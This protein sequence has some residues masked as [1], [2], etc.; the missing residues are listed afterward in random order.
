MMNISMNMALTMARPRPPQSP[1][2]SS[3]LLT[4]ITPFNDP[5]SYKMERQNSNVSRF[6]LYSG[7]SERPMGWKRSSRNPELRSRSMNIRRWDG[8]TGTSTEWD[9]LRKV[10]DYRT[11]SNIY[12][13]CSQSP[14]GSRTLV[15]RRQLQC[16]SV[17]ARSIS[18]RT[19][20][21]S[22][23]RSSFGNQLPPTDAPVSCREISGVARVVRLQ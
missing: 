8:I 9:G 10:S 1:S 23:S 11:I 7:V 22:S 16:A 17:R 13:L 3:S 6:S 2:R 5:E 19:C 18:K 12:G 15:P 14:T 4:T 20:F 21:Q